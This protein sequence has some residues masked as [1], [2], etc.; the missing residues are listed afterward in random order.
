MR[1]AQWRVL[2]DMQD[3]ERHAIARRIVAVPARAQRLAAF[4]LRF[5]YPLI[6]DLGAACHTLGLGLAEIGGEEMI[7]HAIMLVLFSK[8][9]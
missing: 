7:A 9:H 4:E 6:D 5:V 1:A 8:R 2:V 3:V